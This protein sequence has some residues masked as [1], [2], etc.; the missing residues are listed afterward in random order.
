MTDIE[1]EK[2]FSNLIGG[3]PSREENTRTKYTRNNYE[4]RQGAVNV[5]S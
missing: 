1:N 2:F 5:S 4:N 3:L